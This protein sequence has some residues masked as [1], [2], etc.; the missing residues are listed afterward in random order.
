MGGRLGE[1]ADLGEHNFNSDA[2]ATQVVIESGCPLWIGTYEVTRQAC[3]GE[4]ER[5]ALHATGDPAC[6]AVAAM[7]DLY[8]QE[9]RRQV[10]SMY[11]PATLTLG[12]TDEFVTLRHGRFT[13]TRTGDDLTRLHFDPP[14]R[15]ERRGLGGDPSG[16]PG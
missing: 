11:D 1:H 10:T 9:Q 6:L 8:L 14:G 12:Y 4:T 5:A 16:G 13:V 7:L 2:A 3:I 15:T